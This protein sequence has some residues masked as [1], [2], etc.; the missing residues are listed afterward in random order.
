[1]SCVAAVSPLTLDL[2]YSGLP[3]IPNLG[4]EVYAG[5]FD[6]QIGGGPTATIITLDR[7]GVPVRYGTFLSDDRISML[8]GALLEQHGIAYDNIYKGKESP[9]VVTS[10]ASF[11]EDRYFLTYDP[12]INAVDCSDEEIYRALKGAKI[13]IGVKGHDRVMKR[14]REEGTR[15]VFD[16]GWEDDLCIDS[17]KEMLQGVDVF[18]PNEKEALKM[19]GCSKVQDALDIISEYAAYTVI[20]MGK[21]GCLAKYRGRT[22]YMPPIKGIQPVDTTGA[23]DNFLAGLIYGMYHDWSFS[24]SLKMASAVGAYSTTELGCCKAAVNVEKAL[25]L[26]EQ[27]YG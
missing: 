10:I 9:V 11:P 21:E 26:I 22:E 8:A 14:L 6:M 16:V 4:E 23:G 20:T 18:T 15:V 1:M 12:R 7:L 3:R 2:L 25:E 27:T 17:L 5:S 19:T 24:E 13:C